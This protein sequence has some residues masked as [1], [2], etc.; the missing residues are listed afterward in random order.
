MGNGVSGARGPSVV[1][2]VTRASP[3]N[4]DTAITLRK[5]TQLPI[6]FHLIISIPSMCSL[7]Q[8]CSTCQC[9]ILII[10][11]LF[12]MDVSHNVDTFF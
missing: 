6:N 11:H 10:Y 1:A 7:L 2:R 8:I 3:S 5:S 12:L 9:A 4:N